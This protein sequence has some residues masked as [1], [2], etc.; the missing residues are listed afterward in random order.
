MN[1]ARIAVQL[2]RLRQTHTFA[3]QE[4]GDVLVRQSLDRPGLL[5]RVLS[6]CGTR[7]YR[8]REGAEGQDQENLSCLHRLA[9]SIPSGGCA[10]GDQLQEIV[11]DI[12]AVDEFEPGLGDMLLGLSVK[13]RP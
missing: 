10:D 11:D 3:L 1:G 2:R 8:D 9:P 13:A 5:S 4:R 7:E 12:P 6:R